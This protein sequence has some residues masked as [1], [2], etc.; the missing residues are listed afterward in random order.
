MLDC[1]QGGHVENASDDVS[2]SSGHAPS[3]ESSAV[4][5]LGSPSASVPIHSA[6]ALHG[7]RG[8]GAVKIAGAKRDRGNNRVGVVSLLMTG[9]CDD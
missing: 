3:T 7:G 2:G 1:D 5:I 6:S 4:P 8:S 9:N